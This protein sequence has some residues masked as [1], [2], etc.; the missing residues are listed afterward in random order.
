[1]STPFA[2]AALPLMS[3]AIRSVDLCEIR[4]SR[5]QRPLYPTGT[6]SYEALF[7]SGRLRGLFPAF[8]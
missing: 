4:L 7:G 3:R 2:T 8:A 1:M 5:L 6:Q